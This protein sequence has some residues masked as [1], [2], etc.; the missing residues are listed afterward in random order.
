MRVQGLP[1]DYPEVCLTTTNTIE[2]TITRLPDADGRSIICNWSPWWRFVTWGS[3]VLLHEKA[4]GQLEPVE[5][6]LLEGMDDHQYSLDHA[7]NEVIHAYS[8]S[9]WE[10]STSPEEG[11][12]KFVRRGHLSANY[13]TKLV[14]GE[15]Y[16]LLWPGGEMELWGWGTIKEHEGKRLESRAGAVGQDGKPAPRLVLLPA[17]GAKFVAVE[18]DTPYPRRGRLI[19]REG[20]HISYDRANR[21][22]A[23]WRVLRANSRRRHEMGHDDTSSGDECCVGVYV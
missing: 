14:P 9:F 13:Q 12:N 15:R 16:H 17:A 6:G 21:E 1:H 8:H 2:Y 20:P 23:M 11:K 22:E 10:I 7:T 19:T 5:V 18:A 4:D 3:L